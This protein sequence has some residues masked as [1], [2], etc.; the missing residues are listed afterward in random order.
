MMKKSRPAFVFLLACASLTTPQVHGTEVDEDIRRS[1]HILAAA[2]ARHQKAFC[3]ALTNGAQ[4][5]AYVTR[6]CQ[7]SVKNKLKVPEDCSPDNLAQ[8]VKSDAEKCLAMSSDEFDTKAQASARLRSAFVSD[9]ASKGI[10][11]EALLK[12]TRAKLD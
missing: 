3:A 4:Y 8:E 2:E 9:A 6:A 11:G 5:L 1:A 12:E 7:F 10:D